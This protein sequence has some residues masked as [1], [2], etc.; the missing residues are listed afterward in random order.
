[1]SRDDDKHRSANGESAA[2]QKEQQMPLAKDAEAIREADEKVVATSKTSLTEAIK[3]GKR[4]LRAKPKLKDEKPKM[5]FEK[6]IV[7]VCQI[8]YQ[9]AY[10]Y[11]RVA[12]AAETDAAIKGMGLTEAYVHLGLVTRRKPKNKPETPE[13]DGQKIDASTTG[14]AAPTEGQQAGDTGEQHEDGVPDGAPNDAVVQSGAVTQNRVI[15][16]KIGKYEFSRQNNLYVLEVTKEWKVALR[17]LSADN[18][19]LTPVLQDG[20]LLLRWKQ[21]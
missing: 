18:V 10:N 21:E 6:W 14:A 7:T 11:M 4:L 3:A 19:D 16:R 1:M 5:G 17:D 9:R 15:I 13:N 12:K 8:P 2:E 20:G